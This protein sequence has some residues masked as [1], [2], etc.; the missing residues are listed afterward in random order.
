[1]KKII[2]LF[3][4][5][6]S[7]I[8]FCQD[9]EDTY[10][11]GTIAKSKIYMR[12][13]IFGSA[14]EEPNTNGVYFYQNSLKDINFE[15]TQK[16]NVFTL[17]FK[18]QDTI[19]EKFILKKVANN[20]FEGTWSDRKGK[21][22]PVKLSPIDFS[23]YKSTLQEDYDEDEKLNLVK[24]KFLEFKKQKTTIYKN[25]KIDWYSEKHC[26]APL[27]RLGDNFP[28]NNR[29]AVNPVLEK[30][31]IENIL[32][33]LNCSSSFEY[34]TGEGIAY[35]TS[36]TFLNSNLLGF[37]TS[38]NWFCGGAYPDFG[39][40]G[41]LIDLNT[42]K[43]YE[44]DDIIAF[45]KSVTTEKESG[46]DRYSKYRHDYF[47]PKLYSIV[48]AQQHFKKPK[49][50]EEEPCDMTDLNRWEFIDWIYIEKG[51]EFTPSFPHAMKGSCEETFLV[52][53]EK[54]KKYKNPKFKY[55]FN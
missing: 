9:Q 10:L 2:L 37:K 45:D 8:A 52:S 40:K 46:F 54:L 49:D 51:I 21:S 26:D 23:N 15:G 22:F 6:H 5:F 14:T 27:F 42:G 1:M 32:D 44:I 30:I 53:F 17:V 19:F 20:N 43:N 25:K 55:S 31:H 48:K 36:L 34:N 35:E 3:F 28:E 4:I 50:N 18:H 29:K 38:M 47:A 24:L 33:Q 13:H 16:N 39:T 11:E 41:Y 12:I 7:I